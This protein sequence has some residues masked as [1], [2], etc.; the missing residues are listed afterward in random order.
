M[1]WI[2]DLRLSKSPRPP[3][4]RPPWHLGVPRQGDDQSGDNMDNHG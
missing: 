3:K 4:P 2:C 1:I